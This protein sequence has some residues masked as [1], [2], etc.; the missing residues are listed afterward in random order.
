VPGDGQA[1]VRWAAATDNGNPVTGYTVTASPGGAQVTTNGSARS[2]VVPGLADGTAYT[3]T[4]TATNAVGTGPAST[5]SL[6]VTPLP[7]GHLVTVTPTRLVDT[8]Y[9]TKTNPVRTAIAPN[10]TLTVRV[11]GVSG[12]PVPSGATSATVNLMVVSP[13]AAGWL[14]ADSAAGGTWTSDFVAG[15]TRSTLVVSRLGT[16]GTMRV[17][18]H[19]RGT[20]QL[21]ADVQAYVSSAGTLRQWVAPAPARIVDTRYG[22]SS[23]A[24]RTA[25]AANGAITVRVAGV[26]GSPVPAGAVAAALNVTVTGSRAAGFV[27]VDAATSAFPTTSFATGQTIANLTVARLSSSGTA[28]I[29]NHSRSTVH[30]IVDVQGYLAA[31]GSTNQWVTGA[32]VRILDTR[33]G[34]ATNPTRTALAAGASLTVRVA[35]LNGSPVP[36][37]ASAALLGVTVSLPPKAGYVTVD[38]AAGAR[39]ASIWFAAGRSAPGLAVTRLASNGTVV[40]TNHSTAAVNVVMDA[41]GYLH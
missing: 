41:R 11:A 25:V 24:V 10:A 12:S 9:G 26:S 3:F 13:T 32:P 22:T 28:T 17:V 7:H 21:V 30:V 29:V 1:T 20:V 23:N 18:N 27:S 35:G 6:A 14:S 39:T 2:A 37:G 16:D 36:A 33:Y 19:S 8:R 34:T 38:A 4:V 31:T 15:Q 40:V 5:R